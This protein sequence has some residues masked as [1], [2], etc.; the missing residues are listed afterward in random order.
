MPSFRVV[1]EIAGNVVSITSAFSGPRTTWNGSRV[2]ACIALK[3][4][5][6]K[7]M[8]IVLYDQCTSL[9]LV[10]PRLTGEAVLDFGNVHQSWVQP[11]SFDYLVTHETH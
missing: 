11:V 1:Y 9:I 2:D 3:Q 5:Y 8:P 7:S 10:Q 6:L 4:Q